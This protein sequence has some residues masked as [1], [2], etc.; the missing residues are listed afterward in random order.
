MLVVFTGS[1]FPVL[2][3]MGTYVNIVAKEAFYC[4]DLI[5]RGYHYAWNYVDLNGG[6]IA[7]QGSIDKKLLSTS[8]FALISWDTIGRKAVNF[9]RKLC[10]VY[11]SFFHT[12]NE[13][14]S[15][16]IDF[17]LHISRSEINKNRD[18]IG[19]KNRV[20]KQD[21]TGFY[22]LGRDSRSDVSSCP[23]FY[24]F[25]FLNLWSTFEYRDSEREG[26][27]LSN[28]QAAYTNSWWEN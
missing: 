23:H 2:C 28:R 18:Q 11:F 4:R 8:L 13:M 7:R 12:H 10:N 20:T 1:F 6:K 16:P 21:T 19:K 26:M 5:T 9:A 22:T 17:S 27:P 24:L 3:D 14:R 15:K 25:F